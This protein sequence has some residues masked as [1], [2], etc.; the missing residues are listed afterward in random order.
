LFFFKNIYLHFFFSVLEISDDA[1][2]LV[3]QYIL[4]NAL[5]KK[6]HV[7]ARH[8]AIA[9]V[10]GP[11]IIISLNFRHIVR[12]KKKYFWIKQKKK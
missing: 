5:P 7:D 3:W 1:N 6:S 10:N 8:I 12:E 2:K 4:K 9:S 11:D